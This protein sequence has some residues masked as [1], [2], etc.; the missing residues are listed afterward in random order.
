MMP[1]K[2]PM[3]IAPNGLI[4]M[5]ATAPT[6]TPPANVAFCICTYIYINTNNSIILLI[7]QY[8]KTL[9]YTILNFPRPTKTDTINVVK[10]E[11]V[12]DMYVLTM[13]L[14]WPSSFAVA[15]L[16]DGLNVIVIFI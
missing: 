9:F 1:A 10:T 7:T 13:A 14:I 2:E 4:A 5:S 8:C 3:I 11:A 12:I 15:E 6:A 16:K